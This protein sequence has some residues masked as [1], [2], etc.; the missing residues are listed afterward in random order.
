MKWNV[1][2][3]TIKKVGFVVLIILMLSVSAQSL[4][5]IWQKRY[6]NSELKTE[7]AILRA[8]RDSL[9]IA[10][11]SASELAQHWAAEA[12]KRDTNQTIINNHYHEEAHRVLSRPF[13]FRSRIFAKQ[14]N[15][16]DSIGNRTY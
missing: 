7:N 1:S 12:A 5:D 9:R 11:Q 16:L 2:E 8:Q 6:G 4:V 3:S 13:A 15:R 10:A 14:L